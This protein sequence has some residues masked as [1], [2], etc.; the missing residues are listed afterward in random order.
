MFV[1]TKWKSHMHRILSTLTVIAILS[2]CSSREGYQ[3]SGT[4]L[5]IGD[6]LIYLEQRIDKAYVPVDSARTENG[7]FEFKGVVGIPDVYYISLPGKREKSMLFLENSTIGFSVHVDSMGHPRVSGSAVQD[8]YLAFEAGMNSIYQVLDSLRIRLKE[9]HEKS[10]TSLAS[11]LEEQVRERFKKVESLPLDYVDQ[12]PA[13]YIAPYLVQSVHYGKGAAEIEAL[14]AKLDPS[15]SGSTIVGSMNRRAEMLRNTAV[16][17]PAPDFAQPDPEGNMIRLSSFRGKYLLVDFW[18]AWCGPCRRENPNLVRAYK[19]YHD[20]GLE[21]LGV[22]LDNSRE[23]WLKA[24]E[25]DGLAWNHV[26]ELNYWSNSAIR[27][28]G[29]SSIPSNLLIDPEGI[30]IAKNLSGEDLNAELARDLGP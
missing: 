17:N 10:D 8:E 6:T 7:A 4:I 19:K 28:Y 15:L 26:S 21:I 16:G 14:L 13:S 30:I 29:I 2:A 5:G 27:L 1:G 25:A 9:A 18:A 3:L 24:I 20:R 11:G 12:H 22:S 23:Y